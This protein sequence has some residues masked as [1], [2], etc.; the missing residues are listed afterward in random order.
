MANEV[1]QRDVPEGPGYDYGDY[2]EAP[3]ENILAKISRLALEQMKAEAEVAKAEEVLKEKQKALQQ[4]AEFDLPALMK[5]AEQEKITTIDGLTVEVKEVLR[6][7][8]PEANR[9]KAFAWLEEHE[10][11]NL[12]KRQFIIDFNKDEEKAVKKFEQD[13]A[14]RKNPLRVETKKAVNPATLQAFCRQQLEA[15]ADLPLDLFGIYRQNF[16]KVKARDSKT[17]PF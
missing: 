14:K 4:I 9:P 10:H 7:S 11:A 16:A 2:K 5:Q 8:I 1:E 17:T 13:L 12:I 6:G 3:S 15:G